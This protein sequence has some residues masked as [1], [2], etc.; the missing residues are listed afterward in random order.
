MIDDVRCHRQNDRPLLITGGNIDA[1][2]IGVD[3]RSMTVT[4]ANTCC[5]VRK[6]Q[7]AGRL[8]GEILAADGDADGEVTAT[9]RGV[10][11]FPTLLESVLAVLQ[12]FDYIEA[13]QLQTATRMD[14]GGVGE[15]RCAD[16]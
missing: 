6:V 10:R 13:R 12:M 5:C 2:S 8:H 4:R 11:E 9:L 16:R 3:P 7:P 15:N 14:C 1:N